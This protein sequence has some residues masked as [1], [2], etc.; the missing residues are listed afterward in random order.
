VTVEQ[1]A[2]QII[3]KELN[4]RVVVHDDGRQPS[5]NDLRIGAV[6]APEVAISLSCATWRN[7]ISVA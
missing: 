7:A 2:Q 6:E 3:E 4:G 1:W 5:L